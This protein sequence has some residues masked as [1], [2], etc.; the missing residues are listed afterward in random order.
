[1]RLNFKLHVCLDELDQPRLICGLRVLILFRFFP[2]FRVQVFTVLP[3]VSMTS[4]NPSSATIFTPRMTGT[5]EDIIIDGEPVS[6]YPCG[7]SK[8]WS[9]W[10]DQ[11]LK[12]P[13]TCDILSWAGVLDAIFISKACDIHIEARMLRH[14]VRRWSTETHTFICSWGEFT[15][16]L[17]DVATIFHLPLCGSQDPFH[18]VLTT[19]DKLKFEALRKGAPTSP[20]TSL[21]FSNWIQFFGDGNQDEPCRI[22]AFVSLWLG[23]FLFCDFSQDCLHERI[24]PLALAIA[25]G[26]MIPLAPMFLGH[27]YRLLDQILFLEKGTAGTMAVET[28][29]NSSFLQIFLWLRF[30]G[31]KVSPL[32]YPKARSPVDSDAG[33]YVLGNLPL[34]CRWSRRMQRKG[35]KILE[36][37]DDVEQFIFRPYC[38]L[39]EGFR[40][41]PLYADSDVLMEALAMPTQGCRLRREALLSAA[42]L[43][44]PTFGD[45]HSDVSVHYSPYRVR[46]QLGFDQGVPSRPNHGDSLTLHRVFWTGDSVPGD[47][48]PLALALASR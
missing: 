27:L 28:F 45:D 23:R 11:E 18:I 19:K 16:T 37:L 21:R 1:M 25:R 26:S 47:G 8:G 2:L 36:L 24:F 14:V 41:I 35:Q 10:V 42:C 43:P 13:S 39:S 17:E 30:K 34:I 46:R 40:S 4:I 32:P 38:A 7:T 31:I 20:S 33:S 22:V 3:R 15:P 9:E 5:D 29:V 44:L 48:R 12:N 6:E